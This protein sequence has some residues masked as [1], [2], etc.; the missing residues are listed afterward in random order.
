M[1]EKISVAFHTK[2]LL[3]FLLCH[4]YDLIKTD[5]VFDR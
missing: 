3:K 2:E 5:V 1:L 4:W